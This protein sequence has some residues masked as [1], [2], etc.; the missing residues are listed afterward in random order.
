MSGVVETEPMASAPSPLD[1]PEEGRR[2]AVVVQAQQG[3]EIALLVPDTPLVVGRTE[4][5]D[6]QV[7][8]GT[9]SRQHARFVLAGDRLLVED[10]G[11][12]NG[13]WLAGR[14]IDRAGIEIG[15]EVML[16][17]V[18]A[19][20]H[21]LAPTGESLGIDGEEGFLRRVNEEAA[22]ARELRR[23]FALL[24]VRAKPVGDRSPHVRD[25]L[26]AVRE[27]IRPFD[28]IATY[29][30]GAAQVLLPEMGTEEAT[31]VAQRIVA[32]QGKE[33]ASLRVGVAAYPDAGSTVEALFSLSRDAVNRATAERPVEVEGTRAF[34]D[35]EV[36]EDDALVAG[37]AMREV[38]STV[39]RVAGA[40]VP[41][42]LHG[43]TGTGKEVLA[44]ALHERGPRRNKRMVRVNCGA[45]PKEL[46]ESTLFGHERG[47][48]TGAA[49][50]QKGVFEE[51]DGGTVFLDEIG[52]L[53]MPAQAAL[54][55]VLE[56]G[57]L[58]RVGSVREITVDVRVVSATHRD[59]EAMA[60][61]GAFRADLFYR[62]STVVIEIPPLRERLDEIEALA[63]RFLARANEGN[64]RAVKGFSSAVLARLRAY[65]WPGNVRELR[66]VIERAV[67]VAH[68]TLI[69]EE[70]LPARVRGA[71]RPARA[72]VEWEGPAP[73]RTADAPV[74]GEG[75][76]PAGVRERVEGYEATILREALEASGWSRKA[77]AERLGIPVRTLSY[78]MKRL[79]LR[80]P[81]RS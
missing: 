7:H 4:P 21:V 58:C 65:A 59:L 48:F 75:E 13:T 11:S 9:L 17:S 36:L 42:I 67:V 10:L 33:G 81:G 74:E 8:D 29:G 69:D 54:L 22:R 31:R 45:I 12:R 37:R 66:N 34:A 44:R 27:A 23:P 68:G 19:C 56:S 55:R 15:D 43:E 41:V 35:G 32:S 71:E 3:M 77:A 1:A 53:A 46:V 40:R 26:A 51:A 38:L 79:G 47:A 2:L 52:E 24:V 14:R 76:D 39:E 61:D 72:A 60:R 80:R 6:L 78:R 73:T 70:D 63:R 64:A 5:S 57:T 18:L 20:V 28:R 25:W 50:Q 16:G 62:L 49:A 30:P